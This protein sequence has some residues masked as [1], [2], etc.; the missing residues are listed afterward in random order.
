MCIDDVLVTGTSEEE[1]LKNLSEVLSRLENAALHLKIAS[2]ML[3][4][5]QCLGHKI[6]ARGLKL[7]VKKVKASR[8][9]PAPKN[10][11]QLKLFLG[12]VNYYCKFLPNLANKLFLL[13]KSLQHHRK[14]T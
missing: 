13:Y 5:V 7:S 2:L 6:Y 3:S 1:H 8:K 9:V 11:T 4:E 14:W 12:A 10:V